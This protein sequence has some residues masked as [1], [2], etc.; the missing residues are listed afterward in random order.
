M[1]QSASCSSWFN[2]THRVPSTSRLEDWL[3]RRTGLDASDKGKCLTLA[4]IELWFHF[5]PA[6]S[7]V[8]VS[9][10]L[11]QLL[12][13]RKSILF[14][15]RNHLRLIR[16]C[17]LTV[18]SISERPRRN[19][20]IILRWIFV[21]WNWGGERHGLDW[22]GSGKGKVEGSFKRGN[23]LSVSI[24]CGELLAS[25]E[26]ASFSRRKLGHGLCK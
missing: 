17:M 19:E 10:E 9:S 4:E 12:P 1:W 2:P 24:K 22:S 13:E 20:R 8:P 5:P 18:C 14:V 7:L 6:S 3:L 16:T 11:S 15:S 21:K 23:E 25:W 26:P